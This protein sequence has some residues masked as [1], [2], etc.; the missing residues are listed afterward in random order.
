MMKYHTIIAGCVATLF[1]SMS[2]LV[3]AEESE[4]FPVKSQYPEVT[5]DLRDPFWRPGF[6]PGKDDPQL[7]EVKV[8]ALPPEAFQVSGITGAL[9]TPNVT[10]TMNRDIIVDVDEEFAFEYRGKT[11]MLKVIEA[12]EDYI[13]IDNDGEKITVPFGRRDAAP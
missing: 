8:V 13:V 2:V 1:L 9:G 3:L 10:I 4:L 7:T 12:N 11:F 6:T 5:E